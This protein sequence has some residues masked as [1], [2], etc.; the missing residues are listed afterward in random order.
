MLNAFNAKLI[1]C[2]QGTQTT[3]DLG[4]DR[5]IIETDAKVVQEITFDAFDDVDVAA[6]IVRSRH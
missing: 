1:A 5:L 2:L 6:L 3:V 4:I